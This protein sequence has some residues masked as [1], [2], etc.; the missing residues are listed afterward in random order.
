MIKL[1]GFWVLF[2]QK[3]GGFIFD[4]I[5]INNFWLHII[6][7]S[8][9]FVKFTLLK[10]KFREQETVISVIINTVIRSV[11]ASD[12]WCHSRQKLIIL[13]CFHDPT[14]HRSYPSLLM[15]KTR[16]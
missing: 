6:M 3:H 7:K 12:I 4:Q 2:V 16:Q 11:S 9:E 15:L 5:N 1:T 14:T 8:Q 10:H 13:R